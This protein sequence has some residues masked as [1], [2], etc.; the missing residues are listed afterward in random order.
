MKRDSTVEPLS[1]FAKEGFERGDTVTIW[2]TNKAGVYRVK[3][4]GADTLTYGKIRWYHR[5]WK[6]V[7]FQYYRIWTRIKIKQQF[8]QRKA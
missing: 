3:R 8:S 1:S 5:L 4:V 2:N 6:A 7:V